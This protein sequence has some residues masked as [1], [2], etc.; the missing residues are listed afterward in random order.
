MIYPPIMD[1]LHWV[2]LIQSA[3]CGKR[4][5]FRGPSVVLNLSTTHPSQAA[6]ITLGLGIPV[7]HPANIVTQWAGAPRTW[8]GLFGC[9]DRALASG[10]PAGP[11]DEI[12]TYA[13][14]PRGVFLDSSR[15]A[16]QRAAKK[17]GPGKGIMF[18]THK[19]E[20]GEHNVALPKWITRVHLAFIA[21][22]P[23]PILVMLRIMIHLDTTASK[24]TLFYIRFPVSSL[25]DLLST[26][27]H[28]LREGWY[29]FQNEV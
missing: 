18:V 3:A 6:D 25:V 23:H 19:I 20:M 5:S 11:L 13:W 22:F 28:N 7:L 1:Y 16:H 8:G 27:P 17:V 29:E 24:S 10:K 4:L 14:C 21:P 12:K 15:P 9:K 2:V 26:K